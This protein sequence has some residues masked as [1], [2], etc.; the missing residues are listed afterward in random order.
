MALLRAIAKFLSLSDGD[1][2]APRVLLTGGLT[3]PTCP[4]TIW[5][6][7]AGRSPG[8]RIFSKQ[9]VPAFQRSARRQH[10]EGR[11]SH[12]P[13]SLLSRIDQPR[14]IVAHTNSVIKFLQVRL[15]GD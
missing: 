7:P 2:Q 4:G 9:A 15:H 5:R 10:Q 1:D 3:V 11:L 13:D 6:E 12:S 8:R 14:G